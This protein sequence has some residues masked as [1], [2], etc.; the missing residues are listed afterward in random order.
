M[1]PLTLVVAAF[2]AMP[3]M[4]AAQS[5]S[6]FSLKEWPVEWGGR[7][8]DPAVAPDGSV[9][10]V[11]Q[12]GNYVGRFDP[13]TEQFRRFEIEAG[14]NPHTVIVDDQGIAWYAGNRNGR[15]GR[16][17]PAT[18]EI[19]TIMTGEARDPHTMVLDG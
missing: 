9:W 12:A 6:N 15:I 10:F 16:I 8:R 11:G 17:D 2:L 13:S 5:D 18:G 4:A 19:S 14:T 3:A 7:V 1:K